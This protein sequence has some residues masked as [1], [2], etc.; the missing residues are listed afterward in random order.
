MIFLKRLFCLIGK[1]G[2]GKDTVF[3]EL[4]KRTSLRPV[5]TYTT[6]P[7]R[8]GEV[9]GREYYFVTD[10]TME[11][12]SSENKIIEKR[13]YHTVH[14]DWNYFTCDIDF[15]ISEH[16]AMIGT[17]EVVNKLLDYYDNETVVVI[18]LDLDNKERLLRCISRESEQ[19]KPNY[20]EV[21]RR[22]LSDEED[23]CESIIDSC[24][25][26]HRVDSSGTNDENVSQCIK[27][28]NSYR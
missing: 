20:S 6:R 24:K 23:F 27:I 12:L 10:E 4:L 26:L 16:Y 14:G 17:P 22:Y 28:I 11:K 5:V 21:C 8:Q 3:G 7:M 9:N 25:N 15:S 18:Y 13:T 19:T 2:A 1:S